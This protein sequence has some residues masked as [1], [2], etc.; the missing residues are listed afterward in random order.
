LASDTQADA[1][2]RVGSTAFGRR[3]K[4]EDGEIGAGIGFAG[5]VEQMVGRDV[6]LIDS[7][8]HQPHAEQAGVKA[9]FSRWLVEIAVR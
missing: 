7:P 1:R 3:R 8:L 4:I 2:D 5:G 6:I 9:R